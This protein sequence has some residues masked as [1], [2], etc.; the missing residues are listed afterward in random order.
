[1]PACTWHY[2]AGELE[3][4]F[5]RKGFA[6]RALAEPV[7]PVVGAQLT[8]TQLVHDI[9]QR[10]RVLRRRLRQHAVAEVEDVAGAAGG[11]FENVGRAAAEFGRVGQAAPSGRDCLGPRG[12]GRSF[13]RRRRA[14]RANRRRSRAAPASASSGKSCGLPVAKLITGTPGVM[15]RDHLLHVR[16]HERAIVVRRRG[17]RPNCRRVARPARRRRSGR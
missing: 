9:H 1:M 6:R 17:S 13:A 3:Q 4:P 8:R 5:D 11:L 15:P 12:R 10:P 14:A 7:A 16:Q 2:Q